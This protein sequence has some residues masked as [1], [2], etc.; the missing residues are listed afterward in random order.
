VLR[1]HCSG[2]SRASPPDSNKLFSQ[3]ALVLPPFWRIPSPYSP[4]PK[5]SSEKSSVSHPAGNLDLALF[6][7]CRSWRLILRTIQESLPFPGRR[8]VNNPVEPAGP[9]R[10]EV[11]FG[12]ADFPFER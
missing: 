5:G 3:H 2:P 1:S 11:D 12:I 9:T 7:S 4:T 6:F 10:K 8:F